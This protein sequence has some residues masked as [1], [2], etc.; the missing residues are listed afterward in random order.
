M[1][2]GFMGLTENIVYV[3]PNGDVRLLPVSKEE[4]EEEEKRK[5]TQTK[6]GKKPPGKLRSAF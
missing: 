6:R 4:E 3:C 5:K 1:K 2:V